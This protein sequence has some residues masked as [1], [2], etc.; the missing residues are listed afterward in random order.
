MVLESQQQIYL[1]FQQ[2]LQSFQAVY[3]TDRTSKLAIQPA[4]QTLRQIF[5]QQILTLDLDS[6]DPIEAAKVQS[7]HT[8][9][10]R[11][12]RLMGMDTLFI[13]TAKQSTIANQRWEQ[14]ND[15]LNTLIQYC[16]ILLA[17]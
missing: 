16:N 2:S 11:Q 15:R 10:N 17:G 6:L 4:F 1:T 8:E 12:L 7:Y 5:Q 14:V 9:M 3:M 13:Q